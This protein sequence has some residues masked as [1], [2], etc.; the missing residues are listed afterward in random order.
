MKRN[1]MKKLAV[2]V[3]LCLCAVSG[4]AAVAERRIAANRASAVRP[5]VEVAIAG[6]VQRE[7]GL[8]AL[9]RVSAVNPGETLNWTI[10]SRNA[11]DADARNYRTVGQ[12]PQG[13]VFVAGSA[14][15]QGSPTVTY[16]ID[17]GQTFSTTPTVEERQ[18]DGSVRRVP[19]PIASYTQ[20]RY[21]WTDSLAANQ[22][23][24]ASYR[25]RVR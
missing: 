20:V 4:F 24:S 5:V 12:I 23:L 25:V 11:G 7:D 9:E 1:S 8:V 21:E 6:A 14:Q 10:T 3:A 15:G 18:A 2:V 17:G 16:S 13:T 19:A 22:T